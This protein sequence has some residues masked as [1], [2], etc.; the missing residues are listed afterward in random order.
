MRV[1]VERF[2]TQLEWIIYVKATLASVVDL[3]FRPLIDLDEWSC[4]KQFETEVSHQ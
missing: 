2:L 1:L 4:L 3:N